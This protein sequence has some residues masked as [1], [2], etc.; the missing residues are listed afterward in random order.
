MKFQEEI[1]KTL[2]TLKE[3]K[4]ILYPT[5]TVWGIGCD[6]TD[7]VA[8][9]SIFKMK[10]RT[11]SKS[12]IILVDSV[13]MLEKHIENVPKTALEI[14]KSSNRPT[15][16]IYDRPIGLAQNVIANDNTVGIRVA[17]DSFCKQL[18]QEF[19]KPIVSTSA[20]ISG[21]PTPESFADIS[22]KIK[23]SIDYIV[24]MNTQKINNQSSRILR[25]TEND[26]LVIIRE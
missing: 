26:E 16:I 19:G 13:A 6:A 2:Q 9:K 11:E 1:K 17:Q 14:I 21:E 4:T 3:G 25:I 18:I 8:V 7:E 15:S 20:N 23:N 12:L 24:P 5:D 22:L 10:N